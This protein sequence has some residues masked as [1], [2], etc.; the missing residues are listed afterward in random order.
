MTQ[1]TASTKTVT[2]QN[3]ASNTTKSK[4]AEPSKEPSSSNKQKSTPLQLITE[5]LKHVIAKEKL[6]KM[7]KAL[8]EGILKFIRETKESEKKKVGSLAAQAEVSTL[9]KAIKQDLLWMYETLAKQIDG[10]LNTASVT[11]ENS[12]K[13]LADS[14]DLKEATKEVLSKV[15]KVN[16]A[17]DKIAT[18][19]QSYQNVLAQRPLTANNSSL[20]PKV[21]GDM[22]RKA[23]QIL[24]NIFND[25]ANNVLSKSITEVIARAN[26]ALDKI[27]NAKK[28][29]KVKVKSALQSHKGTLILMLNSKEAV[30]WLKQP[31]HE[32]AFT[33]GF[34][35]GSHIRER[36]FNLIIPRVPIVFEPEN[37]MHHREIEEVN[38]LKHHSIRKV[39]WIKPV[40][41]RRMGQMHAYAI[42]TISSAKYANTLIRDGLIV[43]GTR[44]RPEKQKMEPIQ[45]MKCRK[46]GHFAGECTA[47]DNTCGTCGGE[48][49]TN[50][51]QNRSKLWCISCQTTNHASWD[52][53]CPE[54]QRRCYLMDEQNPENNMPYFPMEQD[55]SQIA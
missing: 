48:H 24:I 10:V 38:G 22:E 33:E 42:L 8:L 29:D 45:C 35:K 20:D 52:R 16:D 3:E 26:E 51:C 31:E 53:N 14:K 21:L 30:T 2:Q 1:A 44:V 25:D 28:L 27:D 11:L 37:R 46:W 13:I 23:R 9:H 40:A 5:V 43:C 41:R 55:W 19:T 36:S 17:A 4:A 49:C 12:K 34:S 50:V 7:T 47:S 6:E 54:F 32:M 18:T 15:G 39:R